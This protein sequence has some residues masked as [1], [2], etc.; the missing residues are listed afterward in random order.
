MKQG[1]SKVLTMSM[2]STTIVSF[3]QPIRCCTI[4]PPIAKDT[5]NIKATLLYAKTVPT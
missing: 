2:M 3:A 1:V 5:A 4:Q